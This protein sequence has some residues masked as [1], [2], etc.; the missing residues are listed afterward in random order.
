MRLLIILAFIPALWA[1]DRWTSAQCEN[2]IRVERQRTGATNPPMPAGVVC[3]A[4]SGTLS[5]SRVVNLAPVVQSEVSHCVA[6][7]HENLDYVAC[8]REDVHAEQ[9]QAI[10]TNHQWNLIFL[11]AVYRV[12]EDLQMKLLWKWLHT[13]VPTVDQLVTEALEHENAA[14]AH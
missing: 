5:S 7:L 10:G 14:K 13:G 4:D 11:A 9:V 8:R 12:K 2:Y 6:V 1:Q 3:D